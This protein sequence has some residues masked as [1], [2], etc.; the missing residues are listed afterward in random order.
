[1]AAPPAPISPGT[2][3]DSDSI[4]EPLDWH[5]TLVSDFHIGNMADKESSNIEPFPKL[6][7]C[8]FQVLQCLPNS[9]PL[10]LPGAVISMGHFALLNI[11]KEN[12]PL[13]RGSRWFAVLLTRT[14]ALEA[15]PCQYVGKLRKTATAVAAGTRVGGRG[16]RDCGGGGL[17]ALP[18]YCSLP[19]GTLSTS[20]PTSSVITV[21]TSS[22]HKGPHYGNSVPETAHP[23]G[24]NGYP[25]PV[26]CSWLI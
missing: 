7:G 20:L 1:M 10:S 25:W 16:H 8:L 13:K 24:C 4:A 11:E 3:Q 2:Y 15:N 12:C 17:A 19:N 9:L 6:L 18:R 14:V 21:H 5:D 26:P 22:R 23:A